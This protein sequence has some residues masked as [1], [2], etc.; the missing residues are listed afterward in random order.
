ME[1]ELI[2]SKDH[3]TWTEKYYNEMLSLTIEI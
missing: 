1:A 3:K 2:L